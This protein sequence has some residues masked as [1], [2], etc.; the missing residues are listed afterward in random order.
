MSNEDISDIE[1]STGEEDR[2]TKPQMNWM[3]MSL[4]VV[5]IMTLN[6]QRL[7]RREAL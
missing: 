1:G 5:T 2:L 6:H 3:R 4:A 7:H